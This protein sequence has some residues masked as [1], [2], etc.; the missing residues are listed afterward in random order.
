MGNN[1]AQNTY[2]SWVEQD[3]LKLGFADH[4]LGR[5]VNP[6]CGHATRIPVRRVSPFVVLGNT[7]REA[8]TPLLPPEDRVGA[9]FR[10]RCVPLFANVVHC[11]GRSPGSVCMSVPIPGFFHRCPLGHTQLPT[12]SSF[13]KRFAA[14]GVISAAHQLPGTSYRD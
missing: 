8:P 14:D 9:P 4:E 6:A 7:V 13:F 11:M 3:T 10:A 2:S 5:T 12:A 1:S